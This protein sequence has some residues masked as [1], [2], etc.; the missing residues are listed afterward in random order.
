MTLQP[1]AALAPR[2]T[3][4][5]RMPTPALAEIVTAAHNAGY[6]HF[7]GVHIAGNAL[8]DG[9]TMGSRFSRA[10]TRPAGWR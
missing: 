1:G 3:L 5:P 9:D 2:E 7:L 10:M 6:A 4:I 8:L